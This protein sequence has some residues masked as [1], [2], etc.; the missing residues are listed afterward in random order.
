MTQARGLWWGGRGEGG[1]GQEGGGGV[2]RMA[3]PATDHYT[4]D[5]SSSDLTDK[6]SKM[7]PGAGGV[8]LGTYFLRCSWWKH[9]AQVNKSEMK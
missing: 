3:G 4:N 9:L 1:G 8:H 6:V 2:R 5:Q 7:C